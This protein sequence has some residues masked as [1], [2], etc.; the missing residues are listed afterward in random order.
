[1][2]ELAQPSVTNRPQA[3][4]TAWW[5]VMAAR[6]IWRPYAGVGPARQASTASTTPAMHLSHHRA[7]LSLSLTSLVSFAH[8]AHHRRRSRSTEPTYAHRGPILQSAA[9][10]AP[11]HSALP[12][13]PCSA[14]SCAFG[15]LLFA[16]CHRRCVPVGAS[17][18][19]PPWPCLL[20]ALRA[21]ILLVL[22]S[23][24]SHGTWVPH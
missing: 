15:K 2:S 7:S 1:M 11:P 14:H 3:L 21:F 19:L 22:E 24:V 10:K 9:L 6:H 8:R 13:P 18:W 4:A 5:P 16:L 12:F 20:S 23:P 17:P